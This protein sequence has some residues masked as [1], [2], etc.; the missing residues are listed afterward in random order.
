MS[1]NSIMVTTLQHSVVLHNNKKYIVCLTNNDILFVIDYEDK[2]KVITKRWY[3][4]NGYIG[5]DI[6]N[7]NERRTIYLHNYLMGN[8]T[9]GYEKTTDHKN[10]IPRDNRKK[11][12]NIVNQTEQNIN[13]KKRERKVELPEGCGISPNDIPKNIYYKKGDGNHGDSFVVEIKSIPEI[14]NN[15]KKNS[16]IKKTTKSKNVSLKEKLAEAILICK[17]LL[18]MY[19]D[20]GL[21]KIIKVDSDIDETEC[22]ILTNEFNKILELS[23]FSQDIIEKNKV[24]FKSDKPTI[25]LKECEIEKAKENLQLKGTGKKTIKQL[26]ED[27]PFTYEDLPKYVSIYYKDKNN[28][29]TLY[30]VINRHHPSL[31]EN[32]KDY[33]FSSK[34]D[35]SLLEKYNEMVDK[36]NEL[37]VDNPDNQI[38][39][40]EIKEE[41]KQQDEIKKKQPKVMSEEAKKKMSEAKLGKKQKH[42]DIQDNNI[43]IGTTKSKVRKSFDNKCYIIDEIYEF[44]NKNKNAKQKDIAEI[45]NKKYK[46][47]LYDEQIGKIAKGLIKNVDNMTDEEILE[48][49]NYKKEVKENNKGKLGKSKYSNKQIYMIKKALELNNSKYKNTVLS[50]FFSDLFNIEV[51]PTYISGVK[52]GQN[53]LRSEISQEE[54]EEEIITF[55]PKLDELLIECKK[56]ISEKMSIKA[57]NRKK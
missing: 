23:D 27:C 31:K 14:V 57:K 35:K 45:F 55:I 33:I 43:S 6:T 41:K 56:E 25:I 5:K 46:L 19:P 53:N 9:K 1:S 4:K 3:N 15:P 49:N 36:Y 22:E 34:K 48:F 26:P 50:K 12:L 20:I 11:N 24:E 16:F 52:N 28:F 8:D 42:T 40:K 47:N 29:D 32:K 30:F 44:I 18:K 51:K 54:I 39:K 2:A 21:E 7:N 13:Q 17:D 38:K 10:R 37:N